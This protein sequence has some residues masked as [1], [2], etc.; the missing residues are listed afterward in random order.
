MIL[1][2]NDLHLKIYVISLFLAAEGIQ[3][4]NDGVEGVFGAIA[5]ARIPNN[6]ISV[7]VSVGGKILMLLLRII[8]KVLILLMCLVCMAAKY[9]Y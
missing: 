8:S 2:T 5:G 7:C 6:I 1:F 3:K 9:L 4:V